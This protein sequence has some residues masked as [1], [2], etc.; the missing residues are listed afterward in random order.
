ML[1]Y[2]GWHKVLW[3]AQSS[4]ALRTWLLTHGCSHKS[5]ITTPCFA[6]IGWL[7]QASTTVGTLNPQSV[8][9]HITSVSWGRGL[10]G[11]GEGRGRRVDDSL[12]LAPQLLALLQV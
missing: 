9:V 8:A 2:V 7:P 1:I 11:E 6:N 10:R 3:H 12:C 5:L 4:I